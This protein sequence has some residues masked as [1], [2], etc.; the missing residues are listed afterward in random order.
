MVLTGMKTWEEIE[1]ATEHTNLCKLVQLLGVARDGQG[2]GILLDLPQTRPFF[3]GLGLIFW[4]PSDLSRVWIS[5][6]N[7]GFKSHLLTTNPWCC[8]CM[9][10][11]SALLFF[12]CQMEGVVGFFGRVSF[13]VDQNTQ[14]VHLFMSAL[15]QVSSSFNCF[16]L[17]SLLFLWSHLWLLW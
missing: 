1:W 11:L 15:L 2:S 3:Q 5:K 6:M 10:I 12:W 8:L 14:S 16:K 9:L 7:K 17:K 13:L 4:N